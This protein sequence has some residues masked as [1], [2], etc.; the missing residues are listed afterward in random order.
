MKSWLTWGPSR[1]KL[2]QERPAGEM[3]RSWPRARTSTYLTVPG[4]RK[5][6]GNRIACERLLVKTVVVVIAHSDLYT[7]RVY[8]TCIA[9]VA[10]HPSIAGFRA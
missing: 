8:G 4:K 5:F 3:I 1:K 10:A 7:A 6:A 2:S 9:G